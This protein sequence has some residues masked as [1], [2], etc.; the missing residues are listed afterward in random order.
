MLLTAA[1][2]E[3]TMAD[4]AATAGVAKGTAYLYFETKEALFLAVLTEDLQQFFDQLN[5]GLGDL[6]TRNPRRRLAEAITAALRAPP[7]LLDLLQLLH[8]RLE[9]NVS[10]T[11]L[12]DF[13]LFL[14]DHVMRTGAHIE[15]QLGLAPGAGM[16]G[17]LRTHA[18]AIGIA[19]MTERSEALDRVLASTVQLAPFDLA[20]EAL[21]IPAVADVFR[22]AA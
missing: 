2:D 10:D 12:K 22:P 21:F 5:A 17:L 3:F 7:C 13:K 14:L 1:L 19:Q 15:A 4:L 6:G 18:L 9:R 16:E 8:G 11:A 20:F